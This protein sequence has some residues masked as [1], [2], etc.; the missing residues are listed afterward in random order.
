MVMGNVYKPG[1]TLLFDHIHRRDHQSE[2]IEEYDASLLSCHEGFTNDIA[3]SMT[4]KVEIIHGAKVQRRLL[5]TQDFDVL[6]LWGDFEGVV[7]ILAHEKD[8]CNGDTQF[9][10]RRVML[11]ACH[12]Q[13][14]FYQPKGSAVAIR[15]DK[16][17]VAAAL[18]VRNCVPLVK[19]YFAEKKWFPNIPSLLRNREIRALGHI[20]AR[21]HRMPPATILE[22]DDSDASAG[23]GKDE[24]VWA[25]C[26]Y[27]KP[28]SNDDLR[29]LIPLALDDLAA[30]ESSTDWKQPFDLPHRVLEWF[31]GQKQILF[32]SVAISSFQDVLEA[33][34][35]LLETRVSRSRLD[36]LQWILR[37][38]LVHQQQHLETVTLS[39]QQAYHSR[40]DGRVIKL[41]CPKCKKP[42]G[43][44][45]SPRWAVHMPGCYIIPHRRCTCGHQGQSSV[46]DAGVSHYTTAQARNLY[47]PPTSRRKFDFEPYLQRP[48]K[49]G[50][51][52]LLPVDC[53]CIRC[54]EK[55]ELYDGTNILTDKEPR[56]TISTPSL[57]LE[58]S[59]A[60]KRCQEEL[61]PLSGRPIATRLVPVD[62]TVPSIHSKVLRTFH[63]RYAGLGY[64]VKVILLGKLLPSSKVSRKRK[65]G[66]AEEDDV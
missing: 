59:R 55:T 63:D 14:M 29:K 54:K 32:S 27:K 39:H 21:A 44:D 26:F 49:E 52:R 16:T 10:L 46:A 64:V 45:T 23:T 19:N 65:R 38:T 62:P 8:Y 34:E 13:H 17:M 1:H 37:Q 56:W 18:M 22:Q 61:Y 40:F 12:P 9:R 30:C 33:L 6:P 43:H 31:L 48:E 42:V 15:Q 47:Q 28:H 5:L 11:M 20:V 25:S 60:C 41:S 57:Y 2:A 7:L 3:A 58:R 66:E 50:G 51:S 24:G 35:R 36:A 53:W 4:A